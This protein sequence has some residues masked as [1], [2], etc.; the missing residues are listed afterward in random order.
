MNRLFR[1]IGWLL[2][3]R[4]VNAALSLVYL[5]LAT[6]TLGLEGFGHFALIV[7]LGQ[8]V[9]GLANFQTWQFVVRWGA[10]PDGPGEATGFAIALDLLSVALGSI[11]AAGL[12]WSAQFWLPLPK[13]LLWMAF[14]YCLVMLI[15]I[16]T[17]PTGLLRLRFQYGR[18]TFAEA[19]LPIVRA[20][21]AVLA[22]L[23]MPTVLG[24][25]ITW[26]VA[27][28]A[29]AA[30]MWAVAA[31]H[32]RIDLSQI[33][34]RRIPRDHPG[35]WRFVWATNMT[36]SL[37]V[38]SKQVMILLVGAIGGEALAGAFRVASQLGQALVS[39]AQTIS[40][41]IYPELVH[42]QEGAQAIARR[43]ANI[44]LI[45]GALAVL[46]AIFFGRPA[47]ALVAGPEF[48]SA[49]W[50]MII[51][52]IAGA[53]ELVGASLESLLVSAGRAGT[54]F[55]VRA[56]PTALAFALL[57]TAMGWMGLKGAAFTVM[58]SSALAVMGFWAAI[59][60]MQQIRI[61]V[62]PPEGEPPPI[63]DEDRAA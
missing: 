63:L 4:G 22:A 8:T 47:I 29:V 40:K 35:A 56:I 33:S 45:G 32:E 1:N 21:G 54:A 12:V 42:A 10:G 11:L 24:F 44:A 59:L 58:G 48:R 36:G 38:G 52:A 14:F 41:A 46:A 60:S 23:Y 62:E 25:I 18:A 15:S 9:T 17:T 19:V 3:G 34:F 20:I 2:G 27:E 43:M 37:S 5:A 13:D 57:G 16:R 30:A 55:I 53:I 28:M 61:V 6:R 49:Y 51:L 7:A 50:P 39:L 31:Q 26:A